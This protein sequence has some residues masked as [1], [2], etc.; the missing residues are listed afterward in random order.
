MINSFWRKA[1]FITLAFVVLYASV[2]FMS[3]L[4]I[5]PADYVL[6]LITGKE[7]VD[8]WT[9]GFMV[10]TLFIFIIPIIYLVSLI[11]LWK[12]GAKEND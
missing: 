11:V 7:Y 3:G 10:W 1:P 12:K 6:E 9:P 8:G 4:I 5:Y 2:F